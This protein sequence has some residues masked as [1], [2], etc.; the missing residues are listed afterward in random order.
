MSWDVFNKCY[1]GR[2]HRGKTTQITEQCCSLNKVNFNSIRWFLFLRF[3]KFI[4]KIIKDFLQT[5]IIFYV[6][7]CLPTCMSVHH[8]CAWCHGSQ[9][10]ALELQLFVS[11][12]AKLESPGGTARAPSC[13]A[14]SP[15]LTSASTAALVRQSSENWFYNLI[16]R[17]FRKSFWYFIYL[18]MSCSHFFNY[19]LFASISN[20]LI[21][22][23][24]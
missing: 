21:I 13:W 15:A 11:H 14:T 20:L 16:N 3:T 1:K 5:S 10:K 17:L 7:G 19:N 24:K 4:F 2:Y 6:F 12:Q 9:R 18:P 22:I 23:S 8:L